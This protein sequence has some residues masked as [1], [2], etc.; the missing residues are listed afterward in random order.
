MSGFLS[1]QHLPESGLRE[2]AEFYVNE[3]L[4][5]FAREE[6]DSLA[7]GF[8]LAKAKKPGRPFIAMTKGFLLLALG[9]LL[10][11]GIWSVTSSAL[12]PKES[13]LSLAEDIKGEPLPVKIEKLRQAWGQASKTVKRL[14]AEKVLVEQVVVDEAKSPAQLPLDFE[15]VL[16]FLLE[17]ARHVQEG[18]IEVE[19]VY[20]S[21]KVRALVDG[22]LTAAH[23]QLKLLTKLTER[24][25]MSL[26]F[27][28]LPSLQQLKAQTTDLVP[29]SEF[30][31]MVD[32]EKRDEASAAAATAAEAAAAAGAAAPDAAATTED[33]VNPK[34]PRVLAEALARLVVVSKTHSSGKMEM[35]DAFS[36]FVEACRTHREDLLIPGGGKFPTAAFN[37]FVQKMQASGSACNIF[38]DEGLKGLEQSFT[39]ERTLKFFEDLTLFLVKQSSSLNKAMG[40]AFQAAGTSPDGAFYRSLLHMLE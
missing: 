20:D 22:S 17:P 28:H 14:F 36:S 37:T 39:V 23:A 2:A 32:G 38:I 15:T 16:S 13:P 19:E 1:D 40:D 26:I 12:K 27:L 4:P 7:E 31:Q 8:F 24:Q 5:G 6:E 11:G 3:D 18:K 10:A 9:A 21:T 34:V 29:F 35:A 33:L 25:D 30:L